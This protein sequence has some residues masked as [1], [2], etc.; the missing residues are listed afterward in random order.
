MKEKIIN[1]SEKLREASDRV[2]S[3]VYKYLIHDFTEESLRVWERPPFTTAGKVAKRS[4]ACI[5]G[6]GVTAGGVT[7]V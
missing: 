5:V 7:H 6:A 4:P 2:S 3:S 1:T